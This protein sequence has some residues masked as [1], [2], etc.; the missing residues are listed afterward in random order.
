M[1]MI[2]PTKNGHTL[3]LVMTRVGEESVRNVRQSDPAISDH[4]AVYS[5]VLCLIKP[6][7][8][9]RTITY[10]NLRSLDSTGTL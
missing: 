4:C 6:S 7:F 9:R 3:D 2:P 1:Y 5:E 8:E 10:R